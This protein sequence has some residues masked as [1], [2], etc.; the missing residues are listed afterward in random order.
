M[1]TH[2]DTHRLC[3][4]SIVVADRPGEVAND[5]ENDKDSSQLDLD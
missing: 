5:N 1:E 2:L 3:L 4:E